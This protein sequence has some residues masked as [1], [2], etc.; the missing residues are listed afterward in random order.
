MHAGGTATGAA[1]PDRRLVL[2][3]QPQLE[4]PAKSAH[5]R[6]DRGDLNRRQ[7]HRAGRKLSTYPARAARL[8]GRVP[9]RPVREQGGRPL[10]GRC[11]GS[12]PDVS[13]KR[14]P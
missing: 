7:P 3:L 13:L 5:C 14:R 8:S 9:Q 11:V 12:V 4:L 2:A 6:V 10:P 1:V